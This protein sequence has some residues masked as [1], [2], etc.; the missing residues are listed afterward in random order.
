MDDF[1]VV[2]IVPVRNGRDSWKD[3]VAS[4]RASEPVTNIH[5]DNVLGVAT[6]KKLPC[7]MLS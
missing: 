1:L 4:H 3:Q 7:S 5:P 2:A 6:P